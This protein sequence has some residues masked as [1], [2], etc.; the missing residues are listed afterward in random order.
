M[1]IVKINSLKNVG[2]LNE[3]SYRSEFQLIK[4]IKEGDGK[5]K[6]KYSSKVLVRGDNGTGKSTISSVFRSI[7]EK[8][9]TNKII[10]KIRNISNNE[11]IEIEL[12]LDDGN[13]L[14]Y[15]SIQKKWNNDENICKKYLMRI[16]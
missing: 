15:D 4:K 12:E 14:K 1:K 6:I 9:K 5:T 8:D 11:N 3:D 10:E 16:I 13:K 2:I 7:E